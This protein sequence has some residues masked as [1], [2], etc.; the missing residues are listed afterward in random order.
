[1]TVISNQTK[2]YLNYF[3]PWIETSYYTSGISAT[4]GKDVLIKTSL[5]HARQEPTYYRITYLRYFNKGLFAYISK[6]TRI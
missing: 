1:M 2:R 3:I 5:A 4:T 6:F